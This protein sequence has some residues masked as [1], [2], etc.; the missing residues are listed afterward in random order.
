LEEDLPRRS[1]LGCQGCKNKAQREELSEKKVMVKT[2]KA[3]LLQSE[4]IIVNL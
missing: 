4:K 3:G 1:A 2:A